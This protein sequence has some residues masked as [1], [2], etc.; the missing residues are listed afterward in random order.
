MVNRFEEAVK[1]YLKA[2]DINEK[3]AE[4]HFN[5][6]SAYNDLSDHARAIHHYTRSLEL[7]EGNVDAYICLAGVLE[8]TRGLPDKIEALYREALLRDPDN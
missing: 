3:S 7:D 1:V 8:S 6:A 5:L 4:C 2:L